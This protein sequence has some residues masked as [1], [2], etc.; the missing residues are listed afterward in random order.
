MIRYE[1]DR[2]GWYEFEGLVQTLLKYLLGL[3]VE[4]W[5]GSGDWGRDAYCKNSLSYPSKDPVPGP[6]LFQCKFIDGANAA[7]AKARKAFRKAVTEESKRVVS[8]LPAWEK[9]PAHYVFLTN[10]PVGGTDR[11]WVES[12]IQDVLAKT[13]VH[14]HDGQDIC[15]W[16]DNASHIARAF[17][18][19]LGLRDLEGLILQWNLKEVFSRSEIAVSD[20][21]A[22]STVFVPTGPY[23]TALAILEKHKFVILEGPPEM[24]K[25]AIARMIALTYF[26]RGWQVLECRIPDDLLKAFS[27]ER[28]QI[29]VADDF[30]GRTEYDASRISKWQ[31]DLPFILK[32]LD[33]EHLFAFTTRA[34]LLNLARERIDVAGYEGKFP[35]IGEVIVDASRLTTMDKA[36]MLYRHCRAANL[37]AP[38]RALVREEAEMIVENSHFT[39][40]RI[41]RLVHDV[42]KVNDGSD[43][44]GDQMKAGV[45]ETLAD[46]TKAMS[47]SFG[48]LPDPHK[49]ML[50]S[51]LE[52]DFPPYRL[53]REK[54]EGSLGGLK[55]R[56][57]RICPTEV[58]LPANRVASELSEAF[59]RQPNKKIGRAE[60]DWIHPSVRDVAINELGA[61]S[62]YRQTFLR[63]CGA[64]GL[65]LACSVAGGSKGQVA[66]P[67]LSDEE[68]WTVFADRIPRVVESSPEFIDVLASTIETAKNEEKLEDSVTRLRTIL[69]QV[70]LPAYLAKRGSLGKWSLSTVAE[71]LSIFSDGQQHPLF[72]N[73]GEIWFDEASRCH[74]KIRR[75]STPLDEVDDLLE[76]LKVG[77]S[78]IFKCAAIDKESVAKLMQQMVK[79]MT[80]WVTERYQYLEY[81]EIELDLSDEVYELTNFVDHL[82]SMQ[83]SDAL[84]GL[85]EVG[86]RMNTMR[87]LLDQMEGLNKQPAKVIDSPA[88]STQTQEVPIVKLFADL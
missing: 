1:L 28:P 59:V 12:T 71:F 70:A 17:P 24:G 34:H 44:G 5:G 54:S 15:A 57:E 52:A 16:L 37:S 78:I 65:R 30:F 62:K 72:S 26:A 23:S 85:V 49:W 32:R 9:A 51:L 35:E 7:G 41:R 13:N 81:Q 27:K 79:D 80:G 56:Y 67:L 50:F 39:P 53:F 82:R 45:L 73:V 66:F 63:F 86:D 4:S 42:L 46:P 88:P 77:E 43:Q 36:R 64:E 31:D 48:A 74:E 87:D 75:N 61:K 3:G 68:D 25:T 6:F 2:L 83:E 58:R 60:L 40:E 10:A 76:V 8:R 14:V 69:F 19:I 20:A 29:F 38:T 33:N 84:S 55:A 47:V 21:Q 11:K 22:L 18:Q